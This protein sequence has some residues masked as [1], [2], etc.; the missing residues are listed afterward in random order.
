[1]VPF[2]EVEEHGKGEVDHVR[3][4][5][6]VTA[7][8]EMTRGTVFD[9]AAHIVSHLIHFGTPDNKEYHIKKITVYKLEKGRLLR[10]K[11][12]FKNIEG[13]AFLRAGSSKQGKT[14]F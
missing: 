3:S 13:S 1:M 8:D 12:V 4:A 11:K 6:K 10:H 7:R 2:Y 5:A 14:T 9:N